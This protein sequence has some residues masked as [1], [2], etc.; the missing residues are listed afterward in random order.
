MKSA[1]CR[2]SDRSAATAA[3]NV[4]TNSQPSVGSHIQLEID[5]FTIDPERS[6]RYGWPFLQDALMKVGPTAIFDTQNRCDCTVLISTYLGSKFERS[7]SNR[8]RD[9][10]Y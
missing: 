2:S 5:Q 10:Q 9:I 4:P 1:T 6:P 8:S 7:S 3:V